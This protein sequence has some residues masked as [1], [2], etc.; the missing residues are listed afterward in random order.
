MPPG[1]LARRYEASPEAQPLD[2]VFGVAHV[3]ADR[4]AKSVAIDAGEMDAGVG[5]RFG[6][7]LAA[8][9]NVFELAGKLAIDVSRSAKHQTVGNARECRSAAARRIRH[10]GSPARLIARVADRRD[11]ADAGDHNA[12][13]QWVLSAQIV[14]SLMNQLKRGRKDYLSHRRSLA[15]FVTPINASTARTP[16]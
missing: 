6:G 9:R 12:A 5:Q 2:D 13:V 16:A 4:A 1:L 11:H 8:E 3:G 15:A 10:A 14:G 7:R